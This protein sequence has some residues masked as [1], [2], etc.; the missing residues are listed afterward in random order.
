MVKK[1][2]YLGYEE[3]DKPKYEDLTKKKVSPFYKNSYADV[4]LFA[5]SLAI[6]NNSPQM[7][8]KGKVNRNIPVSALRERIWILNSIAIEQEKTHRALHDKETVC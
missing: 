4:F 7:K 3:D 6:K 2:D 8:L 5:L 1:E